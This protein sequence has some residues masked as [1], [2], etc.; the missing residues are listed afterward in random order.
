MF[1]KEFG[2]AGTLSFQQI[3]KR[4]FTE[5]TVP[6]AG[7]EGISCRSPKKSVK[8]KYFQNFT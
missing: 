7:V 1:D 3:V 4:Q 2:F 6:V 5:G 8:K